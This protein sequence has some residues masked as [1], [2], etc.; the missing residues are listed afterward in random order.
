MAVK[1]DFKKE[2]SPLLGIIFRPVARINFWS[3]RF[4]RW[5]PI[6][7]L[8]DSGADYTLLPRYLAGVMGIELE[9]LK[10]FTTYG[11]GGS[12]KVYFLP[13]LKAKLGDWEKEIPV[14]FLDSNEVPPL[15]G[16]HRF[17]ETFDTLFSK[18]R[19]VRFEN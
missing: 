5:E 3:K 2:V 12:E 10:Q 19:F 15:M 13:K 1:F 4:N 14:G 16:R 17:L 11:V 8:V 18:N 9:K 7:M 6:W